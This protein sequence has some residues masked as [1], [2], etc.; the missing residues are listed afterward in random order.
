MKT[1][2]AIEH[3][4]EEGDAYPDPIIIT[5]A[6]GDDVVLLTIGKHQAYVDAKELL[7]AISKFV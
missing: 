4:T 2:V 7:E 3:Y 6:D 5:E 1:T